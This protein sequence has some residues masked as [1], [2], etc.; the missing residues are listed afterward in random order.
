M[1]YLNEMDKSL[2]FNSMI[3][4]I[5]KT[6]IKL[7]QDDYFKEISTK[8]LQIIFIKMDEMDEI[9]NEKYNLLVL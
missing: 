4:I 3:E 5:N 6:K 8:F 1:G 7:S 9:I 2:I